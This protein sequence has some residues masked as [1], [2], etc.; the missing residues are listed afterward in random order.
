MEKEY[1]RKNIRRE[2]LENFQL[3]IVV[4]HLGDQKFQINDISFDGISFVS[5][6]GY[7]F[8]EGYEMM[9]Y[10]NFNSNIRIPITILVMHAEDEYGISLIGC[11]VEAIDEK[12]K[13]VYEKFVNLLHSLTNF[14]NI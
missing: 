1:L 5:N 7:D 12:A 10:L 6:S 8:E 2:I 4:P 14:V 9:S 3:Y 11:K 13:D